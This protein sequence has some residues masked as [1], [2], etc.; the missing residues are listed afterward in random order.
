MDKMSIVLKKAKLKIVS[1]ICKSKNFNI[2]LICFLFFPDTSHDAISF[3]FVISRIRLSE[4][5]GMQT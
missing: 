1:E 4:K 3:L 5:I 2:I